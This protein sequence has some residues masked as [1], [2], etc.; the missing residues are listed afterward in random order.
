MSLLNRELGRTMQIDDI[1]AQLK[2]VL[3]NFIRFRV[4]IFLA[5]VAVLYG[6]LIVRID[7]LQHIQP[8]AAATV[9]SSQPAVPHI[10]PATV[11]KIEQ[12]QNSSA[13]VQTLFDQAR[14]NPFSE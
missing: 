11:S 1:Q 5:I 13:S 7:T 2:P 9:P 4:P 12:L 14:Q 8:S 3:T 10:D 6:F